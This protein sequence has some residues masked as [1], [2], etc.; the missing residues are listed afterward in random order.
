M[1]SPPVRPIARYRDAA[2]GRPAEDVLRDVANALKGAQ[3]I[4]VATHLNPDGD[5]LG[6]Q[7]GLGLGLR[8]LQKEVRIVASEVLPEKFEPLFLP[9]IIE[10]VRDAGDLRGASPADFAVLLDTAERERTGVPPDAFFGA[11]PRS[12]C[13]DHHIWRGEEA[14][15][16]QLVVTE[17]PSTG[18]LVLALLDLLEVPLT[19]D[20][21]QALWIAVASD[22]GW[23]SFENTTPWA[24]HDAL[25]LAETGLELHPI[26]Q[27]LHQDCP[28]ARAH[29][30]GAVLQGLESS[31]DGA[32]VWSFLDGSLLEREGLALS[33]LDGMIDHVKAIRGARIAALVVEVE[34][35]SFKVSLRAPGR[36]DVETIARRFGG[37]GHAKA[38]GCRYRGTR[39]G[40][41]RDLSAA[42][43][44]ALRGA[45]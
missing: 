31:F 44:E 32:F 29:V 43:E 2:S 42:V 11:A 10:L 18:N 24:L 1:T 26:H 20:I 36:A 6:S 23:F 35:G 16:L 19:R 33:D 45:Q 34:P 3:R 25:R 27:R 17:A 12:I 14:F 9:G 37:G 21:A 4:L 22:T 7:V 8:A 40:L 28:I 30:L 5:A 13:L 39:E 41:F 38:A 15:D